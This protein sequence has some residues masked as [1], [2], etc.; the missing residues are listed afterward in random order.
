ML[1]SPNLINFVGFVSFSTDEARGSREFVFRNNLDL[2]VACVILFLFRAFRFIHCITT[3]LSA[4]CTRLFVH[5][6]L[7]VLVNYCF[8]SAFS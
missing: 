6:A 8:L 4:C 1:I 5:P 3:T 7:L 2:L